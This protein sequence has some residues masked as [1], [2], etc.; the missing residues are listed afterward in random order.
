M[1]SSTEKSFVSRGA[2]K[3]EAALQAFNID[4]NHKTVAD[5][6]S[7][8]GGFVDILL[9]KGAKKVYAVEKGYGTLD[10]GLRN[11]PGVVVMERTD[12]TIV[13]LPESVDIVTIDAGF[14]RQSKLL[15][16]A[17]SL[18]KAGGQVIS[19]LKPQYEASG[20]E[21]EKGQLTENASRQ[22][23]ARVEK[24]LG[25]LG[26]T[27]KNKLLSPVRGKEANA[28]EIFILVEK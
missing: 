27:I 18:L 7:S 15:P 6:G 16:K 10:W 9:R 3:L 5:L 21:L 19:L 26:I 22:I 1:S 4:V 28:Q 20:H 11:D 8:T 13:T 2:L 17:L 23:I 12:A 14:A 25:S 24:E